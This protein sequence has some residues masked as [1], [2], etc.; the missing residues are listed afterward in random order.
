MSYIDT[1]GLASLVSRLEDARVGCPARGRHALK[2]FSWKVTV[3][4]QKGYSRKQARKT[5]RTRFHSGTLDHPIE[6]PFLLSCIS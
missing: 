2:E 4:L 5:M 6:A 3:L 1:L